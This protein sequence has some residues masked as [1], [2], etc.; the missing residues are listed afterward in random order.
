MSPGSVAFDEDVAAHYE[1]WYETPAGQRTDALEKAALRRQLRPFPDARSVLEVGAGT[2]HFTRWLHREG[3]AAVGLDR[4]AAMLR[5]ATKLDGLAWAQGDACH[6][7]FAA[8]TFDLVAFITTLEFLLSPR[9]ALR[10]GLRVARQGLLLGVL[11]RCSPLGIG[12]RLSGLFQP[13]TYDAAHFYSVNELQRL[14]HL[15]AGE[16]KHVGWETI[17]LPTWWPKWLPS[18]PWGGFIAMAL[19]TRK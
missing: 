17:L 2:G 16:D 12:R 14:L 5:Q 19:V 8:D 3:L 10:E 1:A 4:S 18:R 7:P 6:L 13:S 9:Q 11:N 15:V